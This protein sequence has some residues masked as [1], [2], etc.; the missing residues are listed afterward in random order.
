MHGPIFERWSVFGR[1]LLG[2]EHTG[3]TGQTPDISFAGGFGGGVEYK[4]SQ[5]ILIRP[6]G[7]R[8]ASSFSLINNSDQLGNSPHRLWNARGG[9]G[10]A[11]RF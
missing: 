7:D 6:P 8:I 3:G 5:R 4:W 11:Y 1:V 10:V 9:I 2:G